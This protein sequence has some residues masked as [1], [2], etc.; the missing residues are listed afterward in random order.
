[1]HHCGGFTGSRRDGLAL[2]GLAQKRD[3][4]IQV[5][6][7]MSSVNP[8]VLFPHALTSRNAALGTAFIDSLTMGAGQF[9]GAAP[10]SCWPR[11]R[12]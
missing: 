10:S 9:H 7:E 4:P 6:A 11:S 1:M 2:V 12:R 3:V 8:V 5:Y